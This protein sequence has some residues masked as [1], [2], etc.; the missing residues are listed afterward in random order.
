MAMDLAA[1]SDSHRERAARRWLGLAPRYLG[2]LAEGVRV[3]GSEPVMAVEF[4]ACVRNGVE[5]LEIAGAV[6]VSA[7]DGQQIRRFTLDGGQAS[8]QTRLWPQP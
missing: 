8:R 3:S 2:R 7:K 4:M 1:N 5:R 6:E